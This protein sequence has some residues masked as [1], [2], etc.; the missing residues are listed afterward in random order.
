[1]KKI[2]F[3]GYLSLCSITAFAQNGIFLQ[4]VAGIGAANVSHINYTM[5]AASDHYAMNFDGGLLAGYQAGKWVFSSG[6]IYLRTG[7]KAQITLTDALGNPVSTSYMYSR[8]NHL[9]LP[10]EVG[11]RFA[12]GKKLSITP[13]VGA[14]LSYNISASEKDDVDNEVTQI[15]SGA[16]NTYTNTFSWYGILQVKL[17]WRVNSTFDLTCAPTF[18][19]MLTR[20][21]WP[22]QD[23]LNNNSIV[24]QHDYTLLLNFGVKWHPVKKEKHTLPGMRK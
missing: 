22:Q 3:P 12:L 11:R 21:T 20:M 16:S 4:P 8:Y 15:P 7:S 10:L 24:Y 23:P 6:L 1:M 13:S 14:G 2:L 9:V 19:Y 18:D 17:A 5:N